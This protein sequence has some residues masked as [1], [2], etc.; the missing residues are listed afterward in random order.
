MSRF[1][2]YRLSL[3][4]PV[5][6]VVEWNLSGDSISLNLIYPISPTKT[7]IRFETFVMNEDL[8][9][10]ADIEA[11]HVTEMEDEAI[12]EMVQK[13]VG[14]RLYDKGRYSP[15]MEMAVHHFHQLLSKFL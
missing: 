2:S 5:I 12:V 7:Q 8:F 14:S 6:D 9:S 15:N 13:G 10:P 11:T 4:P 3:F 1:S